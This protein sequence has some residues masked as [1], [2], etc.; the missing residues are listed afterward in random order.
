MPY[1]VE[2][3]E[4]CVTT[5]SSLSGN[6]EQNVFTEIDRFAR[7]WN[8]KLLLDCA[9][10]PVMA[11][12]I[13]QRTIYGELIPTESKRRKSIK[14]KRPR[15]GEEPDG[16]AGAAASLV[17]ESTIPDDPRK[18]KRMSPTNQGDAETTPEYEEKAKI[19]MENVEGM[20]NKQYAC[21]ID[22]KV[23]KITPRPVPS[24]NREVVSQLEFP[25]VEQYLNAFNYYF[26]KEEERL[27][28]QRI[29]LENLIREENLRK[30]REIEIA[31]QN[32]LEREKKAQIAAER[33]RIESERKERIR[34]LHLERKGLLPMEKKSNKPKIKVSE[35]RTRGVGL[36]HRSNCHHSRELS[37]FLFPSSAANPNNSLTVIVKRLHKEMPIENIKVNIFDEQSKSTPQTQNTM[38]F[39][40]A[41]KFFFPALI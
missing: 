17:R 40:T 34:L 7:E 2:A 9:K 10:S 20:R 12:T 29:F 27:E 1:F 8:H 3:V 39:T 31:R 26:F 32:Q 14:Q 37:E 28:Q 22:P 21:S 33:A 6:F 41:K 19:I 38:Q 25:Y 11:K 23:Y 5:A 15:T 4:K 36:T 16:A 30:E 35:M 18:S 24:L 13:H